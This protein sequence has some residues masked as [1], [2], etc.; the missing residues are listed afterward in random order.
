MR[1]LVTSL[2][3]AD[4]YQTLR[5]RCAIALYLLILILG[6]IPGARADV[7]HYASGLVLHSGAYGVLSYLI[8]G[9]APG[10][11]K[12]RAIKSVATIMLMGALDECIQSFFPYRGAAISDWLVDC[13]AAVIVALL[14]WAFWPKGTNIP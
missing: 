3:F 8:F 14:L 12:E 9:G 6:S 4:R 10:S 5:Y 11:R 2:L 1:T 13:N 7:G